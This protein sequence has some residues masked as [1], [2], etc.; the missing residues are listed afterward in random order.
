MQAYNFHE[1]VLYR[2]IIL[3]DN[4]QLLLSVDL[5]IEFIQLTQLTAPRCS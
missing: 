2:A 3:S 1:Q 5:V 4:Y